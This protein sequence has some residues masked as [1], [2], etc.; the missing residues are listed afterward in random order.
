MDKEQW[1]AAI[2]KPGVMRLAKSP[3]RGKIAGIDLQDGTIR[4]EP[5][6]E[7]KE[8]RAWLP[9][10]VS[11]V[12]D[13]GC[14]VA[15]EGVTVKGVWGTGGEAWGTLVLERVEPGKVTFA[16]HAGPA[17]LA[18]A[19]DRHAAGVIAG[20]VNLHDVLQPNLGFTLVVLEGFG[21][22]PVTGRFREIL[23]ANEGKLALVDG[24]T[25]LRVGVQRPV[26]ILPD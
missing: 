12:H 17:L 19:R 15:A 22:R 6:L 11:S 14:V 21:Q 10:T 23:C 2:V 16:A 1:L 25:R 7:E 9:G 20:G 26:V 24:T 3:A 18:A 13:R 8:V 5:L 4:I